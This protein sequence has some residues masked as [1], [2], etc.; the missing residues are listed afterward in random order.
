MATLRTLGQVEGQTVRFEVRAAENHL[1][2]LP[3][4]ATEL[5][6]AKVGDDLLRPHEHG[7]RDRFSPSHG[8][9]RPRHAAPPDV[10]DT[11]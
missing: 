11:A 6:R 10:A 9:S 8:E 2:R 5:V 3:A 7:P 1:G 4:L